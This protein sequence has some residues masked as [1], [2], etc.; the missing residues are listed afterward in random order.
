[1]CGP[2]ATA[3]AIVGTGVLHQEITT[4]AWPRK[5]TACQWRIKIKLQSTTHR[6]S[7]S[8]SVGTPGVAEEKKDVK[9]TWYST[10]NMVRS[11][12]SLVTPW[13]VAT[14]GRLSEMGIVDWVIVRET[15]VSEFSLSKPVEKTPKI[16]TR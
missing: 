9:N 5:G 2:M 8:R 1:M 15:G 11:D 14:M 7:P 4:D 13:R 12:D 16:T 3:T 10:M 6:N